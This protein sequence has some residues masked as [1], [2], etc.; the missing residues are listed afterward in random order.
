[1]WLVYRKRPNKGERNERGRVTLIK[2]P[3]LETLGVH[4][5][6]RVKKTQVPDRKDIVALNSQI[7]PT[8]GGMDGVNFKP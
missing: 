5:R 6:T 2:L 3:I 4:S 1:M 7:V 8:V